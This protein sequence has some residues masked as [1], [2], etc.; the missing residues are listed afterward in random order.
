M[1]ILEIDIVLYVL[2]LDFEGIKLSHLDLN[3]ISS[4]LRLSGAAL[5]SAVIFFLF[6][7]ATTKSYFSQKKEERQ[8]L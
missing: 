5:N 4:V 8:N 7:F 2:V 6:F 3:S 1:I